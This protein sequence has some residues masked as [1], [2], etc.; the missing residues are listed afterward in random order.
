[1]KTFKQLAIATT[2]ASTL[3]FSGCG[4]NTLQVKDEAV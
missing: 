1:M 3:L 2:L 4:Y